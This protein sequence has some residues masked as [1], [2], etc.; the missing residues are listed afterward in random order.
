VL[1]QDGHSVGGDRLRLDQQAA[2]AKTRVRAGGDQVVNDPGPTDRQ[3]Y[4][5]KPVRLGLVL[6]PQ[7]RHAACRDDPDQGRPRHVVRRLT[8]HAFEAVRRT[9]TPH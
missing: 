3:A 1:N 4:A 7:M 8:R 6:D 5:D 9:G 2:S